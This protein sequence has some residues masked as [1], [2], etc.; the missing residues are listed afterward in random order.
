MFSTYIYTKRR[1]QNKWD[2]AHPKTAQKNTVNFLLRLKKKIDIDQIFGRI[3]E[4]VKWL[5][6][7][8]AV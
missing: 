4:T 3:K 2:F 5:I 1:L 7:N 8:Q 6:I